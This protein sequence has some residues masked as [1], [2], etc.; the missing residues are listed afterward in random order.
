MWTV[1]IHRKCDEL[2]SKL[3]QLRSSTADLST[4]IAKVNS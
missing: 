3:Q 2:E 4:E 1:S